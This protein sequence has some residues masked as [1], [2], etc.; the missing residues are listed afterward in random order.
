MAIDSRAW[1]MSMYS[2]SQGHLPKSLIIPSAPPVIRRLLL[3]LKAMQWTPTGRGF[4]GR[5]HYVSEREWVSERERE[6]SQKKY[7]YFISCLGTWRDMMSR[8]VL[9]V[10]V[11]WGPIW[12]PLQLLATLP[13]AVNS[14][15]SAPSPPAG[16]TESSH[17]SEPS[18]R[19]GQGKWDY[20]WGGWIPWGERR[21][22]QP[23]QR[24]RSQWMDHRLWRESWKNVSYTQCTCKQN[25]IVLTIK[26]YTHSQQKWAQIKSGRVTAETP[27]LLTIVLL[28]KV[29]IIILYHHLK[30]HSFLDFSTNLKDWGRAWGM[31]LA[32]I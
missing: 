17:W 11:F 14:S 10:S 21:N 30:I 25:L 19:V 9:F 27:V 4:R 31:T 5:E 1:S 15:Y 18:R 2:A 6:Q 24:Q 3:W 16:K 12:R 20:S 28:G 32:Y 13:C 23:P 29:G 7:R 22:W 26:L 8:C